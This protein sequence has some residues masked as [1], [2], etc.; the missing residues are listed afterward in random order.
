MK[1]LLC[2][3][4][5]YMPYVTHGGAN[6]LILE[7]VTFQPISNPYESPILHCVQFYITLGC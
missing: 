7:M 3:E 5:V 2:V 1:F 6:W 4:V